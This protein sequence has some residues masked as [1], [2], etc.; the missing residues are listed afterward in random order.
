[1]ETRTRRT[2]A[3]A[4]P[5]QAAG[6]AC[7]PRRSAEVAG[8][9][10]PRPSAVDCSTI[11]RYLGR[12]V[13]DVETVRGDSPT[14]AWD[15]TATPLPFGPPC[16][17]DR[18]RIHFADGVCAEVRVQAVGTASSEFPALQA[19]FLAQQHDLG[20]DLPDDNIVIT[21]TGTVP[22]APYET[23][24]Q[25]LLLAARGSRHHV[26]VVAS[27]LDPPRFHDTMAGVAILALRMAED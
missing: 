20:W 15:G 19:R 13:F 2:P 17:A 22:A 25:G 18:W 10:P 1:M 26:V 12:T 6:G 9:R 24:Y 4:A 5:D 8:R 11:S 16:D 23:Y 7:S 27:C 3:A 21:A 14:A